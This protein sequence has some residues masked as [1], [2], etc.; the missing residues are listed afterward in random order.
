MERYTYDLAD[1]PSFFNATGT[2]LT[3]S[4]ANNRF[5]F[6]GREYMLETG[7]YDYRNR[8]YHPSLAASYNPTRSASKAIRSIS[9]AT[10]AMIS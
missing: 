9:I 10:A 3:A 7:L 8:F 2:A 1:T 4:S 5:L 6:T